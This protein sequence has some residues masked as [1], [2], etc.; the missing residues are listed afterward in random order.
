MA[1]FF[2]LETRIVSPVVDY[3]EYLAPSGYKVAQYDGTWLTEFVG[4]RGGNPDSVRTMLRRN[5]VGAV[6]RPPEFGRS[7][8]WRGKE[9]VVFDEAGGPVLKHAEYRDRYQADRE[10]LAGPG[11]TIGLNG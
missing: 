3:G 9:L 10:A 11:Y 8:L 7:D 5:R 4:V 6:I 1:D 2:D